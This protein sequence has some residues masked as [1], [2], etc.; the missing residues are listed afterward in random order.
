MD[1]VVVRTTPTCIIATYG[2]V[3]ISLWRG[4][5]TVDDL[6]AIAKATD[7]VRERFQRG[8]IVISIATL[9]VRPPEGDVKKRIVEL[10]SGHAQPGFRGS[11]VVL[12]G[13]GFWAS[14]MR[15]VLAGLN[16]LGGMPDEKHVRTLAEAAT[17]AQSRLAN[18]VDA[19]DLARA[20]EKIVVDAGIR[21]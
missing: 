6:D 7:D 5:V 16:L 18:A 3:A 19:A 17:L 14:V 12:A 13:D 15:S 11:I 21:V 1:A 9:S 4:S 8:H 10:R 2:P 20:L